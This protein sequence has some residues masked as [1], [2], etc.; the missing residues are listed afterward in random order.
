MAREP[1]AALGYAGIVRYHVGEAVAALRAATALA[2]SFLWTSTSVGQFT[3][4]H[5]HRSCAQWRV[6]RAETM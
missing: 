3:L 6:D 4:R 1:L 5:N 2:T